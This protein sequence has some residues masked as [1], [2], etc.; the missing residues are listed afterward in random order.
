M[1]ITVKKNP[2]ALLRNKSYTIIFGKFRL[3]CLVELMNFA[4]N[5]YPFKKVLIRRYIVQ[6]HFFQTQK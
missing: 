2:P 3:F 4:K 5:T 1:Y 6:V